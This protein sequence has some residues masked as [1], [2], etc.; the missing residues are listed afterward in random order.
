MPPTFQAI[1]TKL[2]IIDSKL[3]GHLDHTCEVIESKYAQ[4]IAQLNKR[5]IRVNKR[6]EEVNKLFVQVERR[7]DTL[8]SLLKNRRI[9][10]M[11]QPIFPLPAFDYHGNVQPLPPEFPEC[12]LYLYYLQKRKNCKWN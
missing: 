6:V 3:D 9:T 4:N 1:L 12:A 11:R 10:Y 5:F 8:G 2:D 7:F